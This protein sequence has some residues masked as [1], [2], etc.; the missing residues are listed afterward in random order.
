MFN[1]G[2]T[3]K[4]KDYSIFCDYRAHRGEMATIIKHINVDTMD[5]EV[6]WKDRKTSYVDIKNSIK[7]QKDWDEEKNV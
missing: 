3:I 5:L 1:I 2:D 7:I 6:Q 4:L